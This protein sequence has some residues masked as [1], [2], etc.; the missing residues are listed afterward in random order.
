MGIPGKKKEPGQK[1]RGSKVQ[2]LLQ[3]RHDSVRL[4]WNVGWVKGRAEGSKVILEDF[5]VHTL[6]VKVQTGAGLYQGQ[7]LLL[8]G[9]ST[10]KETVAC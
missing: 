1:H 2:G 8:W 6:G 10:L 4:C 5:E 3:T 7:E 9:R